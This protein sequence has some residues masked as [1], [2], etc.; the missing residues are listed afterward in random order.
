MNIHFFC[1]VISGIFFFFFFFVCVFCVLYTK[2][3]FVLQAIIV[4]SLGAMISAGRPNLRQDVS[5]NIYSLVALST[6]NTCIQ[7]YLE[8]CQDLALVW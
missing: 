3:V 2:S 8:Q 6:V 7:D 1:A 5:L 4:G